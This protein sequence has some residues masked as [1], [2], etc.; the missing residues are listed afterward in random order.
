MMVSTVIKRG[1]FIPLIAVVAIFFHGSAIAQSNWYL[2]LS[3]QVTSGT[4]IY[5]TSTTS[6][7]FYGGL[8]YQTARW[9]ASVDFSAFAQNS[10]L[11]S[12]GGDMF[13]P[14]NHGSGNN[15]MHSGGRG[16]MGNG[17]S[18]TSGFGDV[19]FRGEYTII[20][21][22]T[23]LPSVSLNGL[24][25]VPVVHTQDI[26][27]TGEFDFGGGISLRKRLGQYAAFA[28]AGYLVLGDP[29]DFSYRNPVNYGLGLGRFF[30]DGQYSVLAYYQGYTRILSGFDPPRQLS[31]GFNIRT[32]AAMTFSITGSYGFSETSPDVGISGGI[33]VAL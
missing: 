22:R 12:R 24:I 20:S 13:I 26:Y 8:R 3:G 18:F 6:Y 19:F 11:I 29:E 14:G 27:G 10:D 15:G 9:Y 28:D 30:N 33:T 7:V 1:Y 25:K 32:S 2:N 17:S 31:L 5:D 16:M 21:E 4:Y 23:S